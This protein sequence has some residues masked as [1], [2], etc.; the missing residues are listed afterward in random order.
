MRRGFSVLLAAVLTL[1][2][3]SCAEAQEP[4]ATARRHE[5]VVGLPCEGCD[6]VFEGLP[7]AL[8]SHSRIAPEGETGQPMRIEGTVFDAQGTPA[9]GVIVY[10]YQTN[11]GGIYPPDE[12]LRGQTARRHGRLRG[13]VQTDREGRYRFDTIRPGGYP[14]QN[15]PEHVH[16][17]V[18]E[19]GRC[20]YYIDDIEFED[21]PRLPERQRNQTGGR[22]GKGV[23]APAR[24]PADGWRVVRDIR[25]GQE[26]PGYSQCS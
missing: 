2:A 26:I 18:I 12:R 4:G 17:H 1:G 7:K 11:A 16:L 24:D 8:S 23:V 22:G 15:I 20:T 25:L 9:V 10:A 6:A 19:V 13:W 14:G 21:D 3:L 5:P